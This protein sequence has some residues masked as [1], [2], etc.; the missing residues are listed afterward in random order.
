MVTSQR[1][2]FRTHWELRW[3]LSIWIHGNWSSIEDQAPRTWS[4]WESR[5]TY[6]NPSVCS[7]K[8]LS[9]QQIFSSTGTADA[10]F[11]VNVTCGRIHL[12]DKIC[13]GSAEILSRINLLVIGYTHSFHEKVEITKSW[14]A[15]VQS[16]KVSSLCYV[17]YFEIV[18]SHSFV[19]YLCFFS[20]LMLIIWR[21][22][23]GGPNSLRGQLHPLGDDWRHRGR[24]SFLQ[25][26]SCWWAM[27]FG[28]SDRPHEITI[29]DAC[30]WVMSLISDILNVSTGTNRCPLLECQWCIPPNQFMFLCLEACGSFIILESIEVGLPS[31]H[32]WHDVQYFTNKLLL[33]SVFNQYYRKKACRNA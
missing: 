25:V 27:S 20:G 8:I 15:T 4:W 7:L 3:D 5:L 12:W 10:I 26:F 14:W 21:T 16:A 6:M 22:N 1:T 19:L 9:F 31:E 28:K 2:T 33:S 18:Y 29:T 30:W 17:H 24:T 11:M 23:L 13:W 32:R